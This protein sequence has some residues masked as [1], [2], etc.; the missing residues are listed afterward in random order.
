MAKFYY[1]ILLRG[2]RV[3]DSGDMTF[4]TEEEAIDDANEAISLDLS[5][6]YGI[7]KDCFKICAHRARL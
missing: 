1:E 4:S 3:D 7:S 6:N 2:E 5:R